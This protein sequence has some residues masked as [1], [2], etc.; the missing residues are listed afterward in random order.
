MIFEEKK[1][2]T[3]TDHIFTLLHFYSHIANTYLL[4]NS[5]LTVVDGKV[6]SE[7]FHEAILST[8]FHS[9]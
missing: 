5:Y 6:V 9:E 4:S 1:I 7:G 3:Q 2:K 8:Q